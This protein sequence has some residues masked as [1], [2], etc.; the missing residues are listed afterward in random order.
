MSEHI[1]SDHTKLKQLVAATD[2]DL[3]N[4]LNRNTKVSAT[5]LRAQLMQVVK[6]CNSLRKDVLAYQK[7]LAPKAK[8]KAAEQ[9]TTEHIAVDPEPEPEVTPEPEPEPEPA[10][11]KR[12]GR[13]T[14]K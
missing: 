13:K 8:K 6:L 14:K 5:R 3:N 9:A 11:P 4:L 7:Q 2:Y 12:R 10:K 1:R